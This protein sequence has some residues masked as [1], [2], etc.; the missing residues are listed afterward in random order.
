MGA[1]VDQQQVGRARPQQLPDGGERARLGPLL[2]R[3]EPDVVAG[4]V[5]EPEV[6]R[7]PDADGIRAQDA[8]AGVALR[9]RVEGRGARG[10]R[11]VADD[12]QL[13]VL[14]L[15]ADEARHALAQPRPLLADDEDEAQERHGCAAHDIRRQAN[16]GRYFVATT[17]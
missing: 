14:E 8:D 7:G 4:R 5:L 3:E 16:S 13:D 6:A 1:A 11:R 2:R 12:D 15:G 17:W 9:E 10:R